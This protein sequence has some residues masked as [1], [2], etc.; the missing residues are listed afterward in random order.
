[1]AFDSSLP[2]VVYTT[3]SPVFACSTAE[4]TCS[5]RDGEIVYCAK[6]TYTRG[7]NAYENPR[8]TRLVT[9]RLPA[10]H[11]VLTSYSV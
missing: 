10:D 2:G 3:K 7:L 4:R 11:V 8:V 1:M 9:T 6:R 5:T